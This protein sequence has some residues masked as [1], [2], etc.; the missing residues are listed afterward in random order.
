VLETDGRGRR[1]RVGDEAGRS[2]RSGGLERQRDRAVWA[3]MAGHRRHLAFPGQR[4]DPSGEDPVESLLAKNV[5]E[6]EDGSFD[7][8]RPPVG[9]GSGV[10]PAA[11]VDHLRRAVDADE[12][13]RRQTLEHEGRGDAVSAADLEDI[14][15]RFEAQLVDDP[16]EAS[17]GGDQSSVGKPKR[18]TRSASINA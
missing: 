8:A 3:Q 7:E 17:G 5:I 9:D 4:G 10:A 11:G 12:P 13:A 18:A 2:G 1:G 16:V 6:I 15:R 14:V